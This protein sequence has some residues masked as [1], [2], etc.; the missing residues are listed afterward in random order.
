MNPQPDYKPRHIGNLG[1]VVMTH[2]YDHDELSSLSKGDYDKLMGLPK[3]T[4]IEVSTP[5]DLIGTLNEARKLAQ[6]GYTVTFHL[7]ARRVPSEFDLATEMNQLINDGV[8]GILVIGGIQEPVIRGQKKEDG[9]E[10]ALKYETALELLED[11]AKLGLVPNP[12]NFDGGY[13]EFNQVGI[14]THPDGLLNFT[15]DELLAVYNNKM[16]YATYAN[17]CLVLDPKH[18]IDHIVELRDAGFEKPFMVATYGVVHK[19]HLI[20]PHQTDKDLKD[21]LKGNYFNVGQFLDNLDIEASKIDPKLNIKGVVLHVMNHKGAK[22]EDTVEF[23]E[24]RIT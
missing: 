12:S 9:Y 20:P 13:G 22:V 8:D 15:K 23:L 2:N 18:A 6:E 11:M 7:P 17:S 21:Y 4:E 24:N 19:D 14:V 16:Q 10:A 5:G 1:I 3:G